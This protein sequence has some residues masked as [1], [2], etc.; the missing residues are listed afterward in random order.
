MLRF[1]APAAL[2]LLAGAAFA[3][4]GMWTFD[5]FPIDKA[6]RELGTRI[7][8]AWLDRVRLASVRLGTASG[9]LV[10]PEGPD[11]HQR[12]CRRDL[13]RESVDARAS[14]MPRLGFTP[15]SRAEERHLPRP[16]RRDP[17]RHIDDVTARMQ[18][19]R[20]AASPAWPSPRRATPS[21]GGS[22]ARPAATM[23]RGA[24]RSSRS[25]AAASSSSTPIAATPTFGSPS[26]PSIAPRRSAAISTIS[27]SRASRSMRRW[28][29]S[30]RTAGRSRRRTI[31]AGT[32]RRRGRTSRSSS[33]GSPGA[34]QRLLTQ[35]QLRTVQDVALPLE[36]LTASELRGRLIRFR[37]RATEN[38]FIA[39]QTAVRRREQLQARRSAGCRR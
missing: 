3:A 29:G 9:G 28:C 30:T 39:A 26:R 16:R 10:S 35:A 1:L 24:A 4:E 13:R 31:S 8:Q 15:A 27:A 32:R 20:R 11:P 5:N 34:T 2:F 17:D 23:R 22:R 7:D 14:I 25:I 37:R 6:N 18:R 12:A 38:R 36:Q 33:A 21:P 19:G